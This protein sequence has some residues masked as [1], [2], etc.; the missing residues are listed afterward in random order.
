[1]NNDMK[2]VLRGNEFKRVFESQFDEVKKK[3][4]LKKVDIEVLLYLGENQ[5]HDTPTEIFKNL[6]LNRGHV[7]QA[8]DNLIKK[9]F[10]IAFSDE[11]DRRS[12]H[13]KVSE[14]A[15]EVMDEVIK[16]KVNFDDKMLEGISDDDLEIYKK[17]ALKIIDNLKKM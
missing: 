3:Y 8:L 9:G 13:Y 11:H 5:D 17:V 14:S 10:I 1:M 4:G 12:M 7:S 15:K 16:I 2:K 6:G